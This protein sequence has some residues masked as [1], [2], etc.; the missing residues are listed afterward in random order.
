[1]SDTV[2]QEEVGVPSRVYLGLGSNMGDRELNL[3]RGLAALGRVVKI[4]R[5]SGIWDTEPVGYPDQPRFLN[6]V[7]E[8]ESVLEPMAL[9]EALQ[10][11]ERDLGRVPAFRNAPRPMDIDILLYDARR[12]VMDRLTVPH[13][14][15]LERG[16][17]L[18]PLAEL[19]PGSR[20]PLTGLTL[21]AHLEQAERAGLEG[22]VRVGSGATLLQEDPVI[23]RPD[24]TPAWPREVG[25]GPG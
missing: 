9:L 19:A 5:V 21:A 15:L 7:V 12:I 2:R 24:S 13:P 14:R 8:A 20:H 6:L 3:R 4:G 1:M 16:F 18:R 23:P 22:G 25:G 17:A 11:I 10:R